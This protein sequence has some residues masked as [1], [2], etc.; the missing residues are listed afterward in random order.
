[1]FSTLRQNLF[2]K[3]SAQFTST[4]SPSELKEALFDSLETDGNFPK[5]RVRIKVKSSDMRVRVH[6]E[7]LYLYGG[8]RP[9]F[10][11]EICTVNEETILSGNFRPLKLMQFMMV[12]MPSVFLSTV[13]IAMLQSKDQ[14]W[15][16]LFGMAFLSAGCLLIFSFASWIFTLGFV[17]DER[18]IR[19]YIQK[20]VR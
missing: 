17:D 1:M 6:C 20:V 16:I 10:Y 2:F 12:A 11:G 19:E 8:I 5:D 4:K 13:L 15:Q 3:R 9:V 14:W 18:K 7:H